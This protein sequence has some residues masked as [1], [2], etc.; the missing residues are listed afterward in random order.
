MKKKLALVIGPESSGTRILTEI[1]SEHPDV[2][3]TKEA[4]TMVDVLDEVWKAIDEGDMA[5]ARE[6]FPDLED[7]TCLLTRRSMPH[8]LEV[9]ASARYLDFAD[10][11]ALYDLCQEMDLELIL[12]I[13]TRSTA[14]NLASWTVCRASTEKSLERAKKQYHLSYHYLFGFLLRAEVPYF[15]LSLEALVLDRLEYVQS[16]FQLLG[17]T[18][19]PMRID[20]KSDVN[21]ERYWWYFNQGAEGSLFKRRDEPEP[22]MK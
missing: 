18:F 22:V 20:V 19:H 7:R 13:T 1:L 11:W 16:V 10:L 21:R 8:S 12:L 17:L 2:M 15:L 9:G 5:R 6:R 14:A 4:S 3:G